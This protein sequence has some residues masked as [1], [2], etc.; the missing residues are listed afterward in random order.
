MSTPRFLAAAALAPVLAIGLAACGSTAKTATDAAPSKA[1][2]PAAPVAKIDALSG[3]S[4]SVALDAGFV[5]GLTSLKLTPATVGSATLANGSISFPITGG[6]VTYYTPGSVTPY[7]QGSIRHD[8]SGLSLT[9]GTT[10][11]ELTDFVVD[12]GMSM[13][14]GKVSANGKVVVEGA[15][16][17]FLD[18]S[19]LKPLVSNS[20]G[21]ATLQG[22]TVSLTK[23]AADL[24]N[25]T[26]KTTALVP[27]F[28]VGVAT[29]VVNTK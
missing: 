18:G 15:P 5:A 7:V 1:A 20:D 12:P 19:T 8:G 10:K 14:T 21:T 28:K 6:N 2:S 16:L 3:K 25:Q 27:F 29:I 11:V 13:L 4:T 26:Y 9:D 23:A 22:T 17:F 24:L